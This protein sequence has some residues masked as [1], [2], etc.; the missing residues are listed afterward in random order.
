MTIPVNTIRLDTDSEGKMDVYS[1]LIYNGEESSK[2]LM[3]IELT[4]IGLSW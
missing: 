2:I 3:I 4:I 1:I